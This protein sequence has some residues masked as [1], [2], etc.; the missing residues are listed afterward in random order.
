MKARQP[1]VDTFYTNGV[2]SIV[3]PSKEGIRA[4]TED[5]KQWL[6][7]FY[8]QDLIASWKEEEEHVVDEVLLA[9]KHEELKEVQALI[10]KKNPRRKNLTEDE[11]EQMRMIY[12]M[13]YLLKEDIRKLDRKKD[14][15]DRNNERNRCMYN[16]ARKTGKMLYLEAEC[17]DTII[18]DYTYYMDEDLGED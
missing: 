16:M 4:L 5:E 14:S 17:L 8:R 9:S 13:Y 7:T 3:D 10:K 6:D 15:F 18:P 12:D 11:M 2:A 1:F